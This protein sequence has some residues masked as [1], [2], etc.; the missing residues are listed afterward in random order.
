MLRFGIGLVS[1]WGRVFSLQAS[2]LSAK[3]SPTLKPK[4]IAYLDGIE[5][6]FKKKILYFL[7]NYVYVQE[8]SN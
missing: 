3:T 4:D 6:G 8:H 5:G 2:S 7:S 1:I